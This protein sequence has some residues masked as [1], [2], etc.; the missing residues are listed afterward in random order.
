VVPQSGWLADRQ[1]LRYLATKAKTALAKQGQSGL[2][3]KR[4]CPRRE[5]LYL[6]GS[7]PAIGLRF[8]PNLEI[9]S[10]DKA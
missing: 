6:G 2:R 3:G 7:K 8:Q 10:S 5:I 1:G 9:S 4:L